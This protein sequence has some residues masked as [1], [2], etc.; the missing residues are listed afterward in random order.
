MLNGALASRVPC[1]TRVFISSVSRCRQSWTISMYAL[2][3]RRW[4]QTD[5]SHWSLHRQVRSLSYIC[6][7]GWKWSVENARLVFSSPL[8]CHFWG[9]VVSNC[10]L[11]NEP[12]MILNPT[13]GLPGVL[14]TCSAWMSLNNELSTRIIHRSHGYK[15]NPSK[16]WSVWNGDCTRYTKCQTLYTMPPEY[17]IHNV[18]YQTIDYMLPYNQMFTSANL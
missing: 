17:Q 14:T 11:T 3:L 4:C 2:S 12:T 7:T 13:L 8:S 15:M 18:C 16:W 9:T 1:P 5:G 10:Q 6:H